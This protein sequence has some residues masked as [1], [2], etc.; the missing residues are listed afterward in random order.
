MSP[1]QS[2]TGNIIALRREDID[3]YPVAFEFKTTESENKGQLARVIASSFLKYSEQARQLA[4]QDSI[5]SFIEQYKLYHELM[6][7]AE[8]FLFEDMP[9]VQDNRPLN[10]LLLNFATYRLTKASRAFY[11]E[12]LTVRDV[13]DIQ[14]LKVVVSHCQKDFDNLLQTL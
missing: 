7:S 1:T 8:N 13:A 4:D 3:H 14:S 2:K 10:E 11:F 12:C 6:E 9:F 5:D